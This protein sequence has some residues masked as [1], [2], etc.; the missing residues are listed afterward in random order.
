MSKQSKGIR[1]N[2]TNHTK[3]VGA[4]SCPGCKSSPDPTR[5]EPAGVHS[6]GQLLDICLYLLLL[7]HHPV[8]LMVGMMLI[9]Q[10][11]VIQKHGPKPCSDP[12]NQQNTAGR[13][14]STSANQNLI[15]IRPATHTPLLHIPASAR[16]HTQVCTQHILM[17]WHQLQPASAAACHAQEDLQQR[18]PW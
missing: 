8:S 15:K 13:S 16:A 18:T 10:L 3:R 2:S 7:S 6:L 1:R 4:K 9:R 12:Y 5:G 11:I 17:Q 14:T